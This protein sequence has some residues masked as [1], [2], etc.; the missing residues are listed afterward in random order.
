MKLV[1]EVENSNEIQALLHYI[2]SLSTA[3]VVTPIQAESYPPNK[4]KVRT[5]EDFWEEPASAYTAAAHV[6]YLSESEEGDVAYV[7]ENQRQKW[8]FNRFYGAAKTGLTMDEIDT[9]LNEM[10]QEWERDF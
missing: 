8:D 1:I 6:R 3:K 4:E 5:L 10:R 9:Q 7:A 2:G